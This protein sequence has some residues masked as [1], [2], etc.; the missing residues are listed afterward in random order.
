MNI[1]TWLD[2]IV[3]EFKHQPL[4]ATYYLFSILVAFA[5]AAGI[6]IKFFSL[7]DPAQ[8]VPRYFWIAFIV[9][10][11]LSIIVV[12]ILILRILKSRDS[13]P[14]WL[15]PDM[16]VVSSQHTESV[17]RNQRIHERQD[18]LR[19]TRAT[20]TYF[21]RFVLT[22]APALK[23][24]LLSPGK[25]TGPVVRQNAVLYQ[26]RFPSPLGSGDTYDLHLRFEA[27][28][29]AESMSTFTAISGASARYRCPVDFTLVFPE[30]R[31]AA[32]SYEVCA[33]G[34]G[35]PLHP[36]KDLYCDER[37]G[38]HCETGTIGA[39]ELHVISWT[40]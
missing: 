16:T 15:N 36:I 9:F 7:S 23:V 37:G 35:I 38:Y 28:D 1:R 29:P 14:K 10:A 33:N 5:G 8:A 3:E 4:G 6:V 34:T 18:R 20:G 22:G 40:W 30:D 32:V 19:A 27:S 31:P 21:F 24:F 39:D 2:K 25:L 12:P 17:W 26:V 11:A 13:Q